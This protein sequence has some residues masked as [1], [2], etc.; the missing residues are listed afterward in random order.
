[1][2]FKLSRCVYDVLVWVDDGEAFL[3]LV[4]G[5]SLKRDSGTEF[6]LIWSLVM[7][8]SEADPLQQ[9]R[10]CKVSL[11]DLA[12]R[13]T[14]YDNAFLILATGLSYISKALETFRRRMQYTNGLVFRGSI[15][16]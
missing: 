12:G 15:S 8:S 14:P 9:H 7:P 2:G 11:Y 3:V 13:R 6:M 10:I 5:W 1:M 16:A 4:Q